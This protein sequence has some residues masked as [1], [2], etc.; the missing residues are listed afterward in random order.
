MYFP[1]HIQSFDHI[2]KLASLQA[3]GEPQINACKGIFKCESRGY[4]I[5]PF[6]LDL[7]YTNEFIGADT[8][9]P[10]SHIDYFEKVCGTFIMKNST[11]RDV[12][13]KF[14][15]HL[16]VIQQLFFGTEYKICTHLV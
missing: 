8:E 6:L 4:E 1:H 12:K 9:D 16:A 5:N 14:F 7:M 11:D 10:Y 13:L 3:L 15:G 2:I